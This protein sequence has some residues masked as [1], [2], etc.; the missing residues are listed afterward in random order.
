MKI[1]SQYSQGCPRSQDLRKGLDNNTGLFTI[2]LHSTF[3]L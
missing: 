2:T 3:K 1:R